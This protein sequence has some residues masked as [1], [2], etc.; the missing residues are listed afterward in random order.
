MRVRTV[1]LALLVFGISGC[2][3]EKKEGAAVPAGASPGKEGAVGKVY[4][5]G[6]AQANSQDPWRQVQN[7][8]IRAADEKY[9]DIEVQ[10][11]DAAQDSSKQIGQ[12]DNFL[13]T[14]ADLM[15]VSA[16]E[17]APLTPKVGEVFDKGIPVILMERGIN[18]DKYTTLIGGD[19]VAIGRMAGQFLVDKTGGNG[20]YVEIK[21]VADATPTKDRSAGFHEVADKAPGLKIAESYVC[22]Y[23]REEAIKYVEN[24]IQKK[25]PFDAIYAHNDEMA[26][27]AMIAMKNAGLD[28]KSKII[29]GIDG[30][31]EEAIKAII[32]GEMSATFKYPWL[33]EEA[34]KAA[35][36]ILTGKTVEKKI[37]PETEMVTKEN[38]QAYLDKLPRS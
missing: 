33:G 32:A 19:N 1:A 22:N 38:A 3:Q 7:A 5:V 18:S 31:Q 12:I 17:A 30:V 13:T 4:R 36:D 10:I 27:G 28:P 9:A 26:L 6:F 29:I 11:Q 35:H 34:L 2:L 25:T 23:K 24:L 16:N 21:G 37:T 14:K 15:L 20:T 8:S